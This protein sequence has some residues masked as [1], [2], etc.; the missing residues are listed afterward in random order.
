MIFKDTLF[1]Y[2]LGVFSSIFVLI[3]AL[4]LLVKAVKYLLNMGISLS[5]VKTIIISSVAF[6]ILPS[7]SVVSSII[8]LISKFGVVAPW[9]RLTFTGSIQD[10]LLVAESALN[11]LNKSLSNTGLTVEQYVTVFWVMTISGIMFILAYPFTIKIIKKTKKRKENTNEFTTI[12][13]DNLY[14]GIIA[15]FVGRAICGEGKESIQGDGA[16]ILSLVSLGSSFLLGFILK[17]IL[18]K[19]EIYFK[20]QSYISPICMFFSIIVVMIF[21]YIFPDEIVFYEWRK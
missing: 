19:K 20:I 6:S 12:L 1:L 11:A 9:I 7:I 3:Q 2:S 17:K 18:E 10:N 4:I 8:V 21:A 16:G 5:E 14:I 13:F 15:V